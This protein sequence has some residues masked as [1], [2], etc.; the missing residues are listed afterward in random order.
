MRLAFWRCDYA[1]CAFQEYGGIDIGGK[2]QSQCNRVALYFGDAAPGQARK[3]PDMWG[4]YQGCFAGA[5]C[6]QVAGEGVECVGVNDC[7]A[8][9][10]AHEAADECDCFSMGAQAGAYCDAVGCAICA[11]DVAPGAQGQASDFFHF[12]KRVGHCFGDFDFEYV[13]EAF[14]Y[15]ECDEARASSECRVCRE[16]GCACESNRSGED[17]YFATISFVGV[18]C[19]A[20]EQARAATVVDQVRADALVFNCRIGYPDV[21]EVQFA[22]LGA[23]GIKK[24]SNA[25]QCKCDCAC[26][27]CTGAFD[28]ARVGV[29]SRGY[30]YGDDGAFGAGEG[31]Y[32]VGVNATGRTS[33]TRAQ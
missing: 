25:R 26:C 32:E 9:Q 33:N 11:L 23:T 1:R 4:E 28:F 24:V 7:G 22:A 31:V 13:V 2:F 18:G 3:F 27:G 12:G 30:I 21:D 14:G 10:V 19:A 5:D 17:I 16:C 15:A 20:R 29:E 6:I 8:T